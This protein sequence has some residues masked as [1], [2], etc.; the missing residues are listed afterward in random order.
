MGSGQ[1]AV[2]RR[3]RQRAEGRGQAQG[4]KPQ[5]GVVVPVNLDP[6]AYAPRLAGLDSVNLAIAYDTSRVDVASAADVVR[7]SLTQTF[8]NFTVNLDRAAGIIYISGYRGLVSGGVVSGECG[9]GPVGVWRSLAS[10]FEPM[11][12]RGRRSSTC[13]STPGAR[14][15]RWAGQMDRAMISCSTWSRGRAI[16]RGMCWMGGSMCCQRQG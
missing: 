14:G 3:Q 16:W 9:S 2:G 1:W 15:R 10:R 12:R 13:W 8:D 5:A 11:R 6:G 7:G 4:A